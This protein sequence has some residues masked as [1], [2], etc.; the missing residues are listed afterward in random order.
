M[1][2]SNWILE[3]RK[4][5]KNAIVT[6][7]YSEQDEEGRVSAKFMDWITGW[8][9]AAFDDQRTA[10][11]SGY[12]AGLKNLDLRNPYGKHETIRSKDENGVERYKSH[13]N[14]HIP[15]NGYEYW[16]LG[17]ILGSQIAL[18][19]RY[20]ENPSELLRTMDEILS[21]NES[22]EKALVDYEKG[23]L[24][25]G[26][27]FFKV[28]QRLVFLQELIESKK[29][30][31]PLLMIEFGQIKGDPHFYSTYEYENGD[32]HSSKLNQALSLAISF[33]VIEESKRTYY[34]GLFYSI[35]NDSHRYPIEKLT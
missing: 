2:K 25:I 10:F 29:A 18:K 9:D 28:R 35:Y 27:K 8:Q 19:E 5:Y 21:L 13:E 7:P 23:F 12:D 32:V 3:G 26:F 15:Y 14:F 17:K 30:E 34:R 6:C 20:K 24:K 4:A 33:G 1:V 31:I 16:E 11:E 22:Y